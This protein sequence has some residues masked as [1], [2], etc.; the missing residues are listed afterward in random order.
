M[1]NLLAYITRKG[2][3]KATIYALKE[4][5]ANDRTLN[6]DDKVFWISFLDGVSIGS[7]VVDII[8]V[9]KDTNINSIDI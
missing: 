6:K 9:I 8:S 7:D 3:E 4:E 2:L 1:N 5:I